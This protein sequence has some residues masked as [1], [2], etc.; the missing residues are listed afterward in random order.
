MSDTTTPRTI[1]PLLALNVAAE[2][3]VTPE[4]A[5]TALE[6]AMELLH[7]LG[8]SVD[9]PDIFGTPIMNDVV[10]HLH[11]AFILMTSATGGGKIPFNH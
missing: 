9:A 11:T 7:K 2:K 6:N 8:V 1:S 4:V 10:T 5:D 3:A